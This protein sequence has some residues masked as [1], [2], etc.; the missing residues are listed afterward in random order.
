[1]N[2]HFLR[3][4]AYLIAVVLILGVA[5][6][7]TEEAPAPPETPAAPAPDVP[8]P[9]AAMDEA[10]PLP[11]ADSEEGSRPKEDAAGEEEDEA[12]IDTSIRENVEFGD[13]ALLADLAPEGWKQGPIEHYN[14]ANLYSKIN[15]RSE[16]Y[17]EYDVRGLSWTTFSKADE[18]GV[19][20]DLFIY[21]M[22]TPTNAFGIYSVEREP[23]QESAPFGR[24]AY[25]TGSNYYFWK[26]GH[27]GYINASTNSEEISEAGN[28]ILAKLV[29][30]VEDSNE[31]VEGL[32]WLPEAGLQ[33]DTIQYFKAN[34]FSL[35][36][37]TNTFAAEYEYGETRIRAFV[38]LRQSADDA[39]AIVEK[40]HEYSENYS[41]G[42]ETTTVDGVEIVL[43]DWG[44]GYYD[45]AFQ[46]GEYVAGFTNAEGR[47]T[48]ENAAK[49]LISG[50]RAK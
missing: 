4:A 7:S 18:S 9:V 3:N 19:F 15:G 8:S 17:M 30:R 34:A 28:A 44:G 41:D 42:A 25:K 50:L 16:L 27:Y 5:G 10:P 31:P 1:M 46:V 45:A 36:F 29:D 22:R 39:A 32:S 47:E 24:E 26:G 13:D 21:D 40:F 20:L 35:D 2:H 33:N 6:C 38:S 37:M 48:V 14:V 11:P 49:E 43:A 12:A 23:G